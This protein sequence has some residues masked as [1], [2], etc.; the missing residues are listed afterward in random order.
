MKNR[1]IIITGLQAWDVDIGS[2]CKNLAEEFSR[3][4]RV[5]YV[6]P[7]L[8]RNT[9]MK[10]K[11]RPEIQRRIK[12]LK[13]EEP[14]LYKVAENLWNYFPNSVLESITRIPV[15]A[16]F[17]FMNKRN[18]KKYAAQILKAAEELKFS[19][20]ILFNDN[21][22][23]RSF[24]LKDYLKPNT[25]VYYSRDYLVAVDYWKK[26]GT[27]LEPLL[28]SKSDCTVANSNYL[29]DYAR[30]YN[31]N[32][33]FVGQG[34][35][36][37]LFDSNRTFSIPEDM[38]SISGPI[39]GY[40]GALASLRLDVELLE[41]IAGALNEISF[42]FVGPEDEKFKQ[43]KL[44]ELKNVYFLGRKDMAELPNYVSKFDV[45]LNPQIVNEVTIGNYPRKIDE[46]LALGKKVVA[47]KTSAM[48]IFEPYTYLAENT[49]DYIRLIKNALAENSPELVTKR[50]MF[51]R[52]HTWE[53]NANMIYDAISKVEKAKSK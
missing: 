16:I 36:F 46:Y 24:Y 7:P 1:D 8:D 33:F 30:S 19:D 11:H 9:L 3:S 34:C 29:A 22:I 18:N 37:T 15:P 42:V 5:L 13:G 26:H 53:N 10:E 48:D 4:N 32:S 21:D 44:H 50:I 2:N 31:P 23:F 38:S 43:S 52:N 49:A 17:D 40:V 51:A 27:R 14:Q 41:N 20:Y 39:V 45:C 47:T 25:S 35:D 28:I 12:I 6:N